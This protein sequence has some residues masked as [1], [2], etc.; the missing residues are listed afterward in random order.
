MKFGVV[1]F[2]GSNCDHD[3]YYAVRAN[4]GREASLV[5]HESEDLSGLDAVLLPG[6]HDAD[7]FRR[8]VLEQFDLSLGN[9][10]GKL[11]GKVFR[12]GHLGDFN[13]LMLAGTL[14]GIEMGLD[15]ASV[16]FSKG[17]VGAALEYLTSGTRD[18]G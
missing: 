4:L 12:I 17:G 10:L 14:C 3:A 15:L 8:L 7:E 13:E 2:P 1:L 6:G 16:P 9:G 11:K 5:W 18:K